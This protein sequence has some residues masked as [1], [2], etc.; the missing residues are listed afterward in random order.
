VQLIRHGSAWFGDIYALAVPAPQGSHLVQLAN[1]HHVEEITVEPVE[2]TGSG[3]P[4]LVVRWMNYR[5][6]SGWENSIHERERGIQIWDMD[7]LR[8]LF[9]F[10]YHSSYQRWW[11]VYEEDSTGMAP[12]PEREVVDS[13]GERSCESYTVSVLERTILLQRTDDRPEL[14]EDEAPAAPQPVIRYRLGPAG[15]VRE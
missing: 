14:G 12:Y 8:C 15:M 4:E 5:G 10:V 1:G 3:S 2:F 7:S 9:D 13:G 11:T 6:H